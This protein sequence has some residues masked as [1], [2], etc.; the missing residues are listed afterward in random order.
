MNEPRTESR[1]TLTAVQ[2]DELI[3]RATDARAH[4]ARQ[5]RVEP[6]SLSTLANYAE[7][8]EPSIPA[9]E[10]DE[11][12]AARKRAKASRRRNR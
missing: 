2:A 12:R 3:A 8:F 10:R 7:H 9:S 5:Q 11:R 6:A 4:A 1:P